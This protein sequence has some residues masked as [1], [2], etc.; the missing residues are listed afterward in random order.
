M[1]LYKSVRKPNGLVLNYHRIAMIKIDINQQITLLL[2]SYLNEDGRNYEK[3]YAE[4]KIEEEPTFPY[5]DY[6]YL[7]LDYDENMNIK[8]AYEYLKTL[9]EFEGAEDI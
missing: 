7:N 5:V 8:N 1:A 4:G 9:P 2:Y 6:Q 3:T